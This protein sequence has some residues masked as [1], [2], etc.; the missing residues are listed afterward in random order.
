MGEI[1]KPS[2]DP[3]Q[4]RSE[5]R[6]VSSRLLNFN[7]KLSDRRSRIQQGESHLQSLNSKFCEMERHIEHVAKLISD[8]I[9]E[10]SSKEGQINQRFRVQ[11]GKYMDAKAKIESYSKC[12][13]SHIK[14]AEELS[15]TLNKISAEL[16]SVK[17]KIHE[18]GCS[19]TDDAPLV[20]IRAALQRLR[21]ENKELAVRMGVLVS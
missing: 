4:W 2:V 10:I 3:A 1:I 13:E 15:F 5:L 20:E 17:K 18:R 11:I 19:L 14:K 21:I 16:A 12:K 7:E 8:D 6:L 9:S